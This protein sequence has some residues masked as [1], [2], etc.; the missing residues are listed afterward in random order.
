MRKRPKKGVVYEKYGHFFM[1]YEIFSVFFYYA[2][3]TQIKKIFFALLDNTMARLAHAPQNNHPQK[4]P[5]H[6]K[7]KLAI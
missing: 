7:I 5:D 4:L 1:V 3:T 2:L 6:E